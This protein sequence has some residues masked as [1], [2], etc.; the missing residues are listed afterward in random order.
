MKKTFL[1]G[2]AALSLLAAGPA[3]ASSMI[4]LETFDD[5]AAD[6]YVSNAPSTFFD[7]FTV[8]SG[9]VD[10][11]PQGVFGL[12][13]DGGAGG[14]VDMDGSSGA[15]GELTSD[16]I[17]IQAGFDHDVAFAYSGAQRGGADDL[18]FSIID[19]FGGVLFTDTIVGL[20]FSAPY[21]LYTHSFSV[22]VDVSVS[23]VFET[24]G[25]DNQGPLLDSISV[26]RLDNPPS[27]V[28]L[29]AAAPLM[30]LGLAG[31]GLAARRRKG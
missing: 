6:G 14:C 20:S 9:S 26:F 7:Q 11:I 3:A 4:F 17:A 10:I 31:L 22:P 15:S 5:E 2:A 18:M 30:A 23:L 29:P 24:F 13:C 1:T 28:P 16:L 27:D 25:N 8:T 19:E 21:A 12:S